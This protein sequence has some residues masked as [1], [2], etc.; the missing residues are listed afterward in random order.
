M[1]GDYLIAANAFLG[2]TLTSRTGDPL[3]LSVPDRGRGFP[4]AREGEGFSDVA[5]RFIKLADAQ[6]QR[7]A[8]TAAGSGPERMILV[9]TQPAPVQSLMLRDLGWTLPLATSFRRPLPDRSLR[10]AVVWVG[11]ALLADREREVV[12]DIL[13]SAGVDLTIRN[14]QNMKRDQFLTDYARGDWDLFWVGAHGMFD[15]LEPDETHLLLAE[16]ERIGPDDLMVKNEY[17]QGRRLLVLNACDTGTTAIL[18]GLGEHGLATVAASPVQAV[19][20]HLW[21]IQ[22]VTT[23]P[24]FAG[25]LTSALVDGGSFFAAY[26]SVVSHLS[27]GPDAIGAVLSGRADSLIRTV[28]DH[29]EDFSNLMGWASAAFYE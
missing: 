21:P 16:G 19:I 3:T 20:C 5:T 1:L 24:V 12:A 18:G 7:D 17:A 6:E 10:R 9:P 29:E 26:S 15:A 28:V 8:G 27:G 14:E 25:L 13:G 11:G 23:A 2:T 4:D 22:S